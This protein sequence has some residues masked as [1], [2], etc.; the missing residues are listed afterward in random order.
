MTAPTS[1]AQ[2]QQAFPMQMYDL[3]NAHMLVQA[4]HVAAVLRIA[5]LLADGSRT[6]E[7]LAEASSSHTGSLYRL[8]RL[9]AGAGVFVEEAPG[10]FNLTLLGSTLRTDTPGSVRDWALFIAAPPV[11]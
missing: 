6:V 7:E 4:L 3:L 11:W 2:A 8:L 1:P 9:L 5:D 10:R